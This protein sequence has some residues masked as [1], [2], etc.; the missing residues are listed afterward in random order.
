MAS[1]C[2]TYERIVKPFFFHPQKSRQQ[3]FTYLGL[4][5]LLAL[6]A[7]LSALTLELSTTAVQRKNE[8]E[9]IAIGEEFNHAFEHYYR[10]AT[11]G[12]PAWPGK[13][14]DLVS[15]PRFPNT[16]R[17]L[18][19]IYPNPLNGKAQ[20]GLIPAPGGGIMGVFVIADGKPIRHPRNVL[21]SLIKNK[22]ENPY[23]EWRFGYDP[24]L[25]RQP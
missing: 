3:G 23:A 6:L 15:D 11:T 19:R 5:L 13:L 16:V 12:K 10:S 7:G 18:R 24:L 4:L 14:E 8:V 1:R 22:S 20:W 2:L 17:H 25:L 9:L 21:P